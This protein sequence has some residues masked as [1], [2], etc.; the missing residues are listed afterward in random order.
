VA[1]LVPINKKSEKSNHPAVSLCKQ[2][3][4]KQINTDWLTGENIDE[5]IMV[6]VK[7]PKNKI[8]TN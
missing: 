7:I 6:D 5:N 3:K 1:T 8:I 4:N 2:Y